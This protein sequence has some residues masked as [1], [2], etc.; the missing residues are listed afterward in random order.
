MKKPNVVLIRVGCIA[1]I[2]AAVAYVVSLHA[3]IKSLEVTTGELKQMYGD[4]Y[5]ATVPI[6]LLSKESLSDGELRAVV[7]MENQMATGQL[8]SA[9][10]AYFIYQERGL[11]PTKEGSAERLA[12]L[13]F[14]ACK[15]AGVTIP[16]NDPAGWSAFLA[17][18]HVKKQTFAPGITKPELTMDEYAA[19][20]RKFVDRWKDQF[21]F[22]NP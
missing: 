20:S 4:L 10:F 16:T 7:K 8:R 5:L 14:E 18:S 11:V 21:D 15:K 22:T 2:A 13:A 17:D 19:L 3:K 6:P 1:L 9:L 12:G